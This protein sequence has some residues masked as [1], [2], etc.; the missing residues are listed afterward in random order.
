MKKVSELKEAVKEALRFLKSQEDI[1]SAQ[2][3]AS[4]N[5]RLWTRL[6]YTSHIPCNALE[7]PK[8]TEDYGIGIQA[9]FNTHE[10]KVGFG[11]EERDLSLE[12]VKLALNKAREGAIADPE[13][14]SLP[15]NIHE[16]RTLYDYHDP[17][18]MEISDEGLVAAGWKV[19]D[20][21]M[22]VFKNSE[23]LKELEEK[24]R[25][26]GLIVSGDLTILQERMAIGS[27]E[28]PEVHT[29]ES[30]IILAY[31]TSMIERYDAKGSGYS[32]YLRLKEL[33]DEAG[34]EAAKNAIKSAKGIRIPSGDYTVILGPQPTAEIFRLV[35]QGCSLSTFYLEESPFLGKLGK[36]IAAGILTVVDKG[37]APNLIGS[38]GIT[39]EGLPTGETVLIKDGVLSGLLANW[40]EN[41]R[42]LHD[43]R[44]KQKLGVD[45]HDFQKAIV[46][47]NGFRFAKGGGRNFGI[48]PTISATNVL[49][50][51][52]KVCDYGDLVRSVKKG[53][54]IGRLWYTYPVHGLRAGDFTGTLTAD[55]YLIEEGEIASPI[56]VNTLRISDNINHV[57]R[58]IKE[59]SKEVKPTILWASDEMIY[60]PKGILIQ[61]V[62]LDQIA[63]FIE[64][65]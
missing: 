54:L 30:T 42:I 56:K 44:A 9:V 65:I 50:E 61:E 13:F 8:S 58:G 36:Q 45:P 55:S 10:R 31:L 21:A 48:L 1:L 28:M 38:K 25:D 53:V 26:L 34:R 5:G 51:G 33:G 40:Y 19:L 49:F 60:A 62:H 43:K 4:S 11:S 46:P 14:H 52:S 63:E 41:Q 16:K 35:L 59:I 6:N 39:C 18:I 7:E 57:L 3:F 17:K 2:V 20:G 22:D 32:V 12:G 15:K 24:I 29:D 27:Y 64:E 47:R 37:N 23:Y